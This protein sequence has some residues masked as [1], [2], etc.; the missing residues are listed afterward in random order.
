V[1]VGTVVRVL[2]VTDTLRDKLPPQEWTELQ[3]MVG[4]AFPVYEIDEHGSAWV[5]KGWFNKKGQYTHGHSY[6]LDSHEMEVVE[7]RTRRR[8]TKG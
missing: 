4:Q 3:T 5:E 6:A 2:E 8:P 1:R 7:S